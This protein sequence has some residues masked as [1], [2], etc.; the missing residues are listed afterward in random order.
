[1][2]ALKIHEKNRDVV[3]AIIAAVRE[4]TINA[5]ASVIV[6]NNNGAKLLLSAMRRHPDLKEVVQEVLCFM[7]IAWTLKH[8]CIGTRKPT[9]PPPIQVVIGPDGKPLDAKTGKPPVDPKTGKTITT[10]TTN[11]QNQVINGQNVQIITTT[12]NVQ[13][14][15]AQGKP[16]P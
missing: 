1:M 10:I 9:P 6:A 13:K 5:E 2:V 4:L 11:T 14:V 8:V 15:D 16:I 7:R 3:G 12:T